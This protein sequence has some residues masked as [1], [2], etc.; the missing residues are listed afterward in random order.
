MDISIAFI[1]QN[2]KEELKRA[3]VSCMPG[4]PARHEFIFVDN[5][6]TDGT[7]EMIKSMLEGKHRYVYRYNASNLGVAGARNQAFLMSSGKY[8]FFLDDDA[9]V[10]SENFWLHLIAFMERHGNVVAAS[11]DIQEPLRGTDLNCGY[12]HRAGNIMEIVS[13]CGCAHILRAAFYKKFPRL[14]P[15]RLMFGSEEFYA[16]NLAWKERRCV[17]EYRKIKVAH[18]PSKRNR[19]R[20]KDRDLDLIVN[21]YIIKK[22]NYPVITQPLVWL[23]YMFHKWHNGFVGK[24]WSQEVEKRIAERYRREDTARMSFFVWMSLIKKFGWKMI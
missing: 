17:A 7:Q 4:L 16:S 21:Q 3:I 20:G 6:S 18:Y 15:N 10:A 19:H 24:R 2:R 5:G 9:V 23:A 13:F 22:L 8:V 14:Y 11:V 12:K 1:T